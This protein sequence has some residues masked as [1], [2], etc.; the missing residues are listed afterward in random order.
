MNDPTMIAAQDLTCRFGTTV[1]VDRLSLEVPAGSIV[2]LLGSNGAGKTTTLRMLLGLIPPDGGAS[3]IL[4]CPSSR[5]T[6][7]VKERIGYVP[8]EDVV[9]GWKTVAGM[10]SFHGQFFP[11]YTTEQ[12]VT[13]LKRFDLPPDTLVS[14]LS[15]GMRR[16]LSVAMALAVQPDVLVLDEPAEGFD[17]AARRLLLELLAAFVRDGN[18]AVLL[19]T[20]IL[21]DVE[22]VADRVAILKKARLVVSD[23]VDA[24]KD[25]CKVLVFNG[26]PDRETVARACTILKWTE[27]ADCTE[28]VASGYREDAGLVVREVYGMNLEDIFIHLIQNGGVS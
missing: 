26:V 22:R 2:G 3:T 15:K 4:G 21:G 28:V 8:E 16:R 6:P 24:L 1:A 23:S 25:S 27:Q 14:R 10:M 13:L 9:Y 12:G 20:H 17:P 18:H 5:L 19:S 7:A 11:R